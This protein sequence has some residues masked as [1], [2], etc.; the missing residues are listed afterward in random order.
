MPPQIT[1]VLAF[2]TFILLLSN[3]SVH[4]PRRTPQTMTF[5]SQD[6]RFCW[7]NLNVRS[8]DV[9]LIRTRFS[10]CHSFFSRLQTLVRSSIP[11]VVIY[12][13]ATTRSF[14]HLL[15]YYYVYSVMYNPWHC[16]RTVILVWV[17]RAANIGCFSEPRERWVFGL[18]E[19]RLTKMQHQVPESAPRP[20]LDAAWRQRILQRQSFGSFLINLSHLKARAKAIPKS[21]QLK[22]FW[23]LFGFS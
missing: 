2:P 9:V 16:G 13:F 3:L 23:R 11:C 21:Q 17:Y 19:L 7:T 8:T 1:F 10:V 14:D 4:F 15:F 6:L 18:L 5:I 12:T 20:P 22:K